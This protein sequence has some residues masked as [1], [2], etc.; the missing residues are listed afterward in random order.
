MKKFLQSTLLAFS[1][2]FLTISSVF[3]EAIDCNERCPAGTY[4]APLSGTGMCEC[5]QET[6]RGS[7]SLTGEDFAVTSGT[8]DQLD[9]LQIEDSEY[10]EDFQTPGGIIS[11]ILDFAFPLAGMVLFVMI[12]V[13]GFQMIMGGGEQKALEAGRQRVTTAIVGFILLFA[14]Y[15]IAQ[16]LEQLFNIRIL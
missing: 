15:W 9:P 6:N 10:A 14:S 12:V 5:I 1:L 2:L 4:K 16:L 8:L 11:R 7:D 13:G 3:A